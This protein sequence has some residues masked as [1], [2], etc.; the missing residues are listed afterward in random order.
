MS[1]SKKTLYGFSFL[2]SQSLISSLLA[3]TFYGIA[4]RFLPTVS[5]FGIMTSLIMI[6][7][8]FSVIFSFAMDNGMVKYVADAVGKNRL[9]IASGLIKKILALFVLLASVAATTNYLLAPLVSNLLLGSSNYVFLFQLLSIDIFFVTL[10]IGVIGSLQGLQKFDKIAFISLTYNLIKYLGAIVLLVLGTQL[11]GIVVAWIIASATALI[12][13]IFTIK[14]FLVKSAPSI[15]V[16]TLFSYSAPLYGMDMVN[17]FQSYIDRYLILLLAGNYALG[18]YG[19]AVSLANLINILKLQVLYVLFPKFS[20]IYS[21]H[22]EKAVKD[23]AYHASKYLFLMF[24]PMGVGLAITSQPVIH[25]FVGESY[26]SAAPILSIISLAL[27]FTSASVIVNSLLYS[28]GDTKI[29]FLS[30]SLAIIVD[31][32]LALI[33][34]GPFGGIGAALSK[35]GLLCVMFVIPTYWMKRKYGLNMDFH[36]MIKSIIASGI[37]CIPV[38]ILQLLLKNYLFLPVYVLTGIITYLVSLRFL[39][40]VD[41]DV[42]QTLSNLLP[43]RLFFLQYVLKKILL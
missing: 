7:G 36:V 2:L 30:S 20:E 42:I 6:G 31:I 1:V 23:A 28:L 14:K 15:K 26:L 11:I 24:T 33:L 12:F 37:M 10:F 29:F 32:G 3:V 9:D 25:F 13:S 21:K 19:P 41:D 18:I 17:Y 39:K 40:A 43:K 8:L 34:I 22:G 4:A 16:K 27:V 5:D 35:V 38:I